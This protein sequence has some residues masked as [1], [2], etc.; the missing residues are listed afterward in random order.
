VTAYY[1]HLT[2]ER[3]KD[4]L[5]SL[6]SQMDRL[7]VRVDNMVDAL[8]SDKRAEKKLTPHVNG[9]KNPE[10]RSVWDVAWA[11]DEVMSDVEH[12]LTN[13][14]RYFARKLACHNCDFEALKREYVSVEAHY[15]VH[16]LE[17]GEVLDSRDKGDQVFIDRAATYFTLRGKK[18]KQAEAILSAI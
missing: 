6:Y 13:A 4:R 5:K 12:N 7:Y 17:L 14:R 8:N 11:I 3:I 15:D 9:V 2:P 16:L 10:P 1:S 18:F